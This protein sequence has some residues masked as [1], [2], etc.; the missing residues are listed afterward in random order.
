MIDEQVERWR[1]A[2]VIDP[3]TAERIRAFELAHGAPTRMRWPALVAL[4]LGGLMLGAGLLLFVAAHW[5]T[6][7][8]ASRLTLLL[9]L[10]AALHAAGALASD[11][12]PPLATTLH[13]VGTAALGAT[14]FLTGQT[15]HLQAHWP[16]GILLWAAGA[17]AGYLLLRSWPQGLFAALLTPAWLVAE[18]AARAEEHGFRDAAA[19]AAGVLLLAFVYLLGDARGHR[20]AERHMLAI[21]GAIALIPS[22]ILAAILG[23]E[24]WLQG[25]VVTPPVFQWLSWTVALGGP[26]GLAWALRGRE[27]WPGIL[28][29]AWAV[30]GVRLGP[31]PGVIVY[32]WAAAGAIGLPASGVHDGDRRRV[33]L[34]V[35]AFAVTVVVF[36]FSS[37]MDK[38]GRATSLAAG[39][40]LLLG[41]GWLLER[42]RRRLVRS[43]D[44]ATAP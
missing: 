27:A 24:R 10:L 3:A 40:V 35:A 15:Y 20:S 2:G 39:G 8:P 12:L 18:W 7:A 38:F 30:S 17:W 25:G 16:Q 11:R 43:T 42:L 19:P 29:A 5:P 21:V 28:A 6:L 1:R 9:T 26:L 31:H 37:V 22:G 36:Y 4:G 13:A 33:N 23:G 44:G 32:L 41:L 34:G 14:I